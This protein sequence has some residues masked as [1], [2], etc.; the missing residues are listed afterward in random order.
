M[1]NPLEM[2]MVY[3]RDRAAWRAWLEENHV[4]EPAGVWLVYFKPHTGKPAVAYDES[5]EEALC[6]GWVDS[7]IRKLDDDRYARKFTPRK[8]DSFWSESNRRRVDKLT[9]QGLMTAAGLRLVEAAQ[10]SGRWDQD[11]R[12]EVS[13]EPAPEFRAALQASPGAAGFFDSLTAAQQRQ[14]VTWINVAK[15]PETRARRVVESIALLEQGKKLGM[16]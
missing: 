5:V 13:G 14:F 1:S 8:P 9:E 11:S 4:S 2:H 7:L 6:F 10:A 3:A 16:K 12:P 15:R